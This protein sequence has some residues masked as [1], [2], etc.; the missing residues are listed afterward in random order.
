MKGV[1][2]LILL[3]TNVLLFSCSKTAPKETVNK[4]IAMEKDS[5]PQVEKETIIYPVAEL[6]DS[7]STSQ[8][9]FES[10]DAHVFL[11]L[12]KNDSLRI[13]DNSGTHSITVGH[14]YINEYYVQ[15]ELIG[16]NDSMYYSRQYV[17]VNGRDTLVA[18]W[19]NKLSS[20]AVYSRNYEPE[21]SLMVVY[22]KPDAHSDTIICYK[23][24]YVEE[25][26]V[27]D[28]INDWLKVVLE[29]DGKRYIGWLPSDMQCGLIYTTCN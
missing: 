19:I 3:I 16:K 22:S 28:C 5:Y 26:P 9:D 4:D 11:S 21:K 27:L 20:L 8:K 12:S 6:I 7:T 13:Y 23:K 24:Q 15:C 1:V 18:G 29:I 2:L 10:V 14:D 17:V 25:M